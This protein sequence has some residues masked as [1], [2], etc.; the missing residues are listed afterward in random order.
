MYIQ[1]NGYPMQFPM[2]DHN[3]FKT[4]GYQNPD[5]YQGAFSTIMMGK[6]GPFVTSH[7][8]DVSN[9]SSMHSKM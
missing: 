6:E 5:I 7:G 1:N 2:M 3:C 4:F 9:N 8:L